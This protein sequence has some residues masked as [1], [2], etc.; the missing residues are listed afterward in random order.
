MIRIPVPAVSYAT[1]Q[2]SLSGESYALTFRF[3]ERMNRW[4]LD[5]SEADGTPVWNGITLIEGTIPT[6]HLILDNL[7]GGVIGVFQVESDEKPAG[8]DNLGIG[9][10]YELVYVDTVE[11]I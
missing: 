2:V 11:L 5:I 4:K 1:V 6:A 3:N 10:S 8:R 7:P 9:D